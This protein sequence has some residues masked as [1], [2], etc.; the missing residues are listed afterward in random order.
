MHRFR[1]RGIRENCHEVNEKIIKKDS[2]KSESFFLCENYL[3]GSWAVFSS[4][5]DFKFG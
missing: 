2:E 5:F 3:S 1:C 4:S